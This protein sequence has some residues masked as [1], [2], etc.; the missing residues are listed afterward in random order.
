MLSVREQGVGIGLASGMA[1]R[2]PEDPGVLSPVR[3]A[4]AVAGPVAFEGERPQV[5]SRKNAA[6]GKAGFR[7]PGAPAPN[8]AA[9][10]F[11][12]LPD[13][14]GRGCQPQPLHHAATFAAAVAVPLAGIHMD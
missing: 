9:G 4:V 12:G 14:T 10:L 13:P 11:A 1:F 2:V 7:S 6:G 3:C 5:H 8:R